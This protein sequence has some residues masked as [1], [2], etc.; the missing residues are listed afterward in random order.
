MISDD[1]NIY[2]LSLHTCNVSQSSSFIFHFI[3]LLLLL[4]LDLFHQFPVDSIAE[5]LAEPW[6]RLTWVQQYVVLFYFDGPY[7]YSQSRDSCFVFLFFFFLLPTY[8][9][10]HHPIPLFMLHASLWEL[11]RVFFLPI[12]IYTYI[13]PFLFLLS[14]HHFLKRKPNFS[15][16]ST[17]NGQMVNIVQDSN[18]AELLFHNNIWPLDWLN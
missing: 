1:Y 7:H 4:L 17:L 12:Y 15:L 3:L 6:Q 14:E 10:Y 2:M 16:L 13:I 5:P 11:L 9:Y 18:L 8:I